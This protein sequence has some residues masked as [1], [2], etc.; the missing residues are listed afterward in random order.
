MSNDVLLRNPKCEE[1]MSSNEETTM[2]SV[3]EQVV[4]QTAM[5]E[6]MQPEEST[7][8]FM[9]VFM[10]AGSNRTYVTEDIVSRWKFKP[11]ESDKLTIFTHGITK[12]NEIV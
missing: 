3:G 4:M 9:R 6:V 1:V 2:L 8:E 10:N 12:P 5:V 7:S 11:I